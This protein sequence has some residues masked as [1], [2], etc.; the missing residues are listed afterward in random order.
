MGDHHYTSLTDTYDSDPVVYFENM[1]CSPEIIVEEKEG[2]DVLIE[3]YK[4]RKFLYDNS[5]QDFKNKQKKENAWLE[6]SNIMQQKDMGKY[7]T[8]EYCQTRC[9][10]LRDQYT[11]EKRNMNDDY[12]ST[13]TSRRKAF[14]LCNQLSF[15]DNF[16]KRRR[17]CRY[18]QRTKNIKNKKMVIHK[19]KSNNESTD[20]LKCTQQNVIKIA[21]KRHSACQDK[22]QDMENDE[23]N[24]D[25]CNEEINTSRL[26][27][28]KTDINES[29][30]ID[31]KS[32]NSANMNSLESTKENSTNNTKTIDQSFVNYIC[33]HLENIPEPEK[34]TRKKMIIDALTAPL[35]KTCTFLKRCTCETLMIKLFHHLTAIHQ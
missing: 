7:Y 25:K 23:Q 9:T 6:I 2:D 26:K 4:E 34:S 1:E 22:S 35:P 29:Q 13:N 3:L 12:K 5:H 32:T 10:S 19:K 14:A 31:N 17:T 8:P 18:L 24:H 15:L 28:H 11:R 27:R 21:P 20:G 30:S 16:I 33:V